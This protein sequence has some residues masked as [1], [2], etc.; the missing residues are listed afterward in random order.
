MGKASETPANASRF[1]KSEVKSEKP[2]FGVA[3]DDTKPVLQDPIVRSDPMET[4]EAVLRLP[5]F[6]TQ[7]L[8]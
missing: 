5:S 8:Q 1:L 4:E 2:P 7:N 6:P 3:V